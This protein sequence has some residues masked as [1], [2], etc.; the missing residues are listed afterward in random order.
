MLPSCQY[1]QPIAWPVHKWPLASKQMCKR[2]IKEDRRISLI[3]RC[4]CVVHPI[5]CPPLLQFSMRAQSRSLQRRQPSDEMHC[6][7]PLSPSHSFSPLRCAFMQILLLL[8]SL[9]VSPVC[10]KIGELFFSIASYETYQKQCLFYH[11]WIILTFL[12]CLHFT[13]LYGR[14]NLIIF[15]NSYGTFLCFISLT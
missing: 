7:L 8:G 4:S 10:Q 11:L 12:H 1:L 5:M 13:T 14:F 3:C 2:P 9:E 15:Q 6:S